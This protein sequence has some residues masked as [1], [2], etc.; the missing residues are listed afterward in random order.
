LLSRSG[1][2]KSA[3]AL[4]LGA[5]LALLS[6]PAL[7]DPNALWNIV[8]TRCVPSEEL[9]GDPAPCRLVDL[10][11]GYAVLKDLVGAAQFLLI[12]TARVTGIESPAILASDA[13]NYF[14]DAWRARTYVDQALHRTLPREDVSLAINSV[15]GRSQNQLHIHV[16]CV[17]ADVRD[18]LRRDAASIG[19]RWSPLPAPLPPGGGHRYLAMHVAGENL[20]AVNPFRALANGVPSA[21]SDMGRRTLVVV[22]ITFPRGRPGFVMLED[23]ANPGTGDMASGEELQDHTCAVVRP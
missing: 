23:R 7:A 19:A 13:P 14:A 20:D 22:G 15:F 8:S 5:L 21:R 17:R 18:A 6:G 9:H 16:D 3:A 11:G 2:P 10:R 12:P 1:A 4:A